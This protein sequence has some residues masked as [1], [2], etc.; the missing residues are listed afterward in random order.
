VEK[1]AA[2]HTTNDTLLLPP[3]NL[4]DSPP[5]HYRNKKCKSTARP[6]IDAWKIHFRTNFQGWVVISGFSRVFFQ[7]QRKS[8]VFQGLPR[9][10][11]FVGHPVISWS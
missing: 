9:C 5:L 7:R 11:G 4:I 2:Y 3:N 1:E 10:P 8:R 6:K